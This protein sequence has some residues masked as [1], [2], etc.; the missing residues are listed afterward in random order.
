MPITRLRSHISVAHKA[1]DDYRE[2]HGVTF[3]GSG[4]EPPGVD[5]QRGGP[6][7]MPSVDAQRG[8]PAWR[9]GVGAW[10]FNG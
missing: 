6:A 2:H 10:G 4:V 5:A 7:W 9:P 3:V 1:D 8:C